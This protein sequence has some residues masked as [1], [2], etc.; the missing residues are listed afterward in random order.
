MTRLVQMNWPDFG[1]P[2]L[3][4]PLGLA[5]MR[6]RMT[7]FRQV[8]R[9]FDLAVIYGD[10]EHFANI[11]WL[12]GFDP[13]FEEAVLIISQNNA[14]LLAGN[15]CLSYTAVA[16]MVLSGEIEVGLC[17]SFSLPSQPREGQNLRTWLEHAIPKDAKVAA[18]GW[19]WFTASEVEEPKHAVDIPAFIIDP[20]RKIASLVE[21]ATDLMM[22]PSYGLRARVDAP[23]IARL[24]YANWQAAS[25]LKRMVHSFRQGQSDFAAC[26]AAQVDGSALGCHSTFATG[27]RAHLGLSGPTGQILTLGSQI[28]FNVCHWGANICRAGWLAY[29]DDDLPN[30]AR[31]YL[32]TFAGPY[33]EAMSLWCS[34]MQPGTK[35]GAVWAAIQNAL[36]Y[37]RF[38]VFLNPGHLIGMDEWMSSPI[39]Q[40]SDEPLT[41]GMAMQMDVIPS[42]PVYGSTRMEDGYVIADNPVRRAVQTQFPSVMARCE[43]RAAFMRDIIGL[44]VPQSLLPL[45][46]TCGIVAPF[47]FAPENVIVL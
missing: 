38:G 20:L 15:E 21:N 36:P 4:P 6:A 27:E 17:S 34:L 13:R 19:K 30:T 1:E 39:Y 25:A 10:R 18:I 3:P 26:R 43:K 42:H 46:D 22:H 11:H 45:A 16:P 35:G 14:L 7:A 8:I 9:P 32:A 2:A 44:D 12:T 5:E 31:D 41:S 23:E 29:R 40:G 33:V 28:S 24:E 47:L 37:D